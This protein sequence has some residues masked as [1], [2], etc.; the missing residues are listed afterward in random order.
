MVPTLSRTTREESRRRRLLALIRV[1]ETIAK[2]WRRC[3]ARSRNRCGVQSP[4]SRCS[5]EPRGCRR[6]PEPSLPVAGGW[7]RAEPDRSLRESLEPV[8]R[9]MFE[10]PRGKNWTPDCTAGVLQSDCTKFFSPA[11]LPTGPTHFALPLSH[12]RWP[13]PPPAPPVHTAGADP[14]GRRSHWHR[15]DARHSRRGRIEE[16]ADESRKPEMEGAA[17][18]TTGTRMRMAA[19]LFCRDQGA[20]GL[21]ATSPSL[22][23]LLLFPGDSSSLPIRT[24][25]PLGHKRTGMAGGRRR[26]RGREDWRSRG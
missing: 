12:P 18:R 5:L 8:A 3:A 14:R 25:F 15:S 11:Q 17:G 19:L 21:E 23:I 6:R 9:L 10:C 16:G 26:E 7:S 20:A 24:N 1:R 22:D 4:V 2:V 13:S